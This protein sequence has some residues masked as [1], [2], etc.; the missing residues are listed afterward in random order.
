MNATRYAAL[1]EAQQSVIEKIALGND[2]SS[3]LDLICRRI[4]AI[5]DSPLVRSSI[6]ILVGDTLSHA[7]APSLPVSYCSAVDGLAIGHGM[8]S[9]GTAA[10][11]GNQ[12]IVSD[13]GRYRRLCHKIHSGGISV[14]SQW[15]T[16]STPA[17]L[18]QFG[19]RTIRLSAALASIISNRNSLTL[20]IFN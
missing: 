3:C 1:L 8:G 4:E 17:G 18:R 7:A 14:S 2:L 13:I 15:S 19:L 12:I 11:T 20:S 16:I 5:I 10:Y 6:M 9:C